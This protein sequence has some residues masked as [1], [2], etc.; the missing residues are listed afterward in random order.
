MGGVGA[1]VALFSFS[2]LH[3][4]YPCYFRTI[5]YLLVTPSILFF[6][7]AETTTALKRCADM[8]A[9]EIKGVRLS[10]LL[11]KLS[12]QRA[13]RTQRDFFLKQRATTKDFHRRGRRERR[14]ISF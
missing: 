1:F 9:C 10:L 3:Y 7:I 8:G 11:K 14:G 2:K 12:P 6:C 13:Q 4:S 5:T